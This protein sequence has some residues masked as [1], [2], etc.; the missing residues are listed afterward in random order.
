[1]VA[2]L[3]ESNARLGQCCN[4]EVQRQSENSRKIQERRKKDDEARAKRETL[5]MEK[6]QKSTEIQIVV[7]TLIMTVAFAAGFTLPGGLDND[8]GPNKGMSILSKK[9]A[10]RL[11]V[12]SDVLAFTCAAAAIYIYSFMADSDVVAGEIN[13]PLLN[14]LWM[15][16]NIASNLQRSAMAAVV[17][18]FVTGIYAALENSLALA[19]SVCVIGCVFFSFFCI[20]YKTWDIITDY[21][22]FQIIY[23]FLFRS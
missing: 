7:A 21:I 1:M 13:V 2:V 10:F 9:T 8:N 17:V 6:I 3:R 4:F 20:T 5:K 12:I 22:P 16:Y 11:F 18:A 19:V 15:N 23:K 14:V